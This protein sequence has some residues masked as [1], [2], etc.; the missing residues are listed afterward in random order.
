MSTPLFATKLYL[1]P[2]RP[3]VVPR[4]RLLT[5]LNEGLHRPLTLIAA[6]AGFGKTTLV[7]EWVAGCERPVAW[8][9]LDEGD[10]DL[11]H[12]L[13]YIIAALQTIV[14]RIGAGMLGR[15]SPR[16]H[17]QSKRF[18]QT[19]SMTSLPCRTRSSSSSTTIT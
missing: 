5:R 2:P 19:C 6:P 11:A 14:P 7:S 13:T 16:S 9:S 18:S 1:P 17:R 8:L 15:S 12:F 4:L 10:D 3:N